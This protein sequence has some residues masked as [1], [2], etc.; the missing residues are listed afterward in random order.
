MDQNT[1]DKYQEI[2]NTFSWDLPATFN[3]GR[4]VID[5]WAR[6]T[7]GHEALI[8]CDETGATETFTLQTSPAEQSVCEPAHRAGCQEG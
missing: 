4:D 2:Y 6:K 8:W 3:Y 5:E 1:P 7:P